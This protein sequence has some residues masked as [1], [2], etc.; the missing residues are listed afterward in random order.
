M[1]LPL[2]VALAAA[3]ARANSHNHR[4]EDGEAVVL[5]VNK[6]GSY[7]NPQE[8]YQYYTLPFCKVHD[9]VQQ[10]AEGLGEALEG[11]ELINS[12]YRIEFKRDVE[13]TQLCATALDGRSAKKFKAAI[14]HHYW[15]Q[16]FLDDLPIWSMVGDLAQNGE[17]GDSQTYL[18]T[19]K[20]FSISYNGDRVIAVNLTSENPQ[21]V[22]K[23][24]QLSFSY[25]VTW[26]PTTVRFENRFDKYLDTSFFEHQ[27]HIFSIFNSFMMVLFLT[28]LVSMILMRALKKD[29][30]RFSK[31]DDDSGD[32]DRDVGD[33]SGWKQLHGDVFRPP[34][35]LTLL[36]SLIGTGFHL[37]ILIFCVIMFSILGALY[38]RRGTITTVFIVSYALTSFFG[39]YASGAYFARNGGRDWIRTMLVTSLLFP[40]VC[41]GMGFLLNF[42]AI[43]YASLAAIPFGTMVALVLIWLCVSFPLTVAGT[44]LGR[45]WSGKSNDPCRVNPIPRPIPEKAFWMSPPILIMLGGLLPFGSIFIEMYFIFTSFWAYKY[46]YVYG[47]MLVVYIILILVTICVTI[48]STYFLL[49]AED[50]RW[51]WMSYLSAASIG[52]YAFL[53][54]IYFFLMKTRMT[55]FFQI[56]FYFGYLAIF[57]VGLAATCG[58]IG[59]AGTDLF[60]KRI[61]RSVKID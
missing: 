17:A 61:Y 6:I 35:R 10:S 58:Y 11:N 45:N 52:I 37:T 54:G 23:G 34:P 50:Y 14:R 5:W 27:I 51:Q 30:A 36:S 47:F 31:E 7:D 1:L 39:G 44:I 33:E 9:K 28:G 13:P 55:G 53:Y 25:S 42:V 38:R 8:T 4:Y 59:F 60:V 2:L 16:F 41:F 15:A 40:G 43:A 24:A 49:N 3:P 29:F 18:Y 20:R 12:G 26:V 46:Y 22:E 21:L 56:S 19:H 57:C 32:L 48:V